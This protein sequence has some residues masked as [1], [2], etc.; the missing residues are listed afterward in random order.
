MIKLDIWSDIVCPWCYIGKR[1]MERALEGLGE[2]VQITWRSFELDPHGVTDPNLSLTEMLARKYG[3]SLERA[4]QAQ[5]QV[6]QAAKQEGLD[7]VFDEAT[8]ANTFHAHRLLQFARTEGKGGELKERLM[9]AYFSEGKPVGEIDALAALA[10]EVGLPEERVREVLGGDEFGEDVRRDEAQAMQL[11]VRG[12]PF[13]VINEAYGISGAQPTEVFEQVFETVLAERAPSDV[14]DGALCD[15][16][17]VCE[18][19]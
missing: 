7:F 19:P 11:G 16:D 13:F 5:D 15:D 3:M 12:V 8:P 1:R 17:G 6:T 10:I 2:E 4:R 14:E 18:V 9:R